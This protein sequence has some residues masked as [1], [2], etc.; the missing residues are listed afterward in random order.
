MGRWKSDGKGGAYWDENDSGP[1]QVQPSPEQRAAQQPQ[2]QSPPPAQ[3]V[4]IWNPGAYRDAK[5]W[6][7][8]D[9]QQGNEWY[10]G[11]AQGLP[12]SPQP[13]NREQFRDEWMSTGT[14]VGRQ[15]ALL[16][17]YGITLDPA[18]RGT[19]QTTD[20]KT[21]TLDLRIGA[22]AG[23]NLAAWTGIGGSGGAAGNEAGSMA[24][25][26]GKSDVASRGNSLNDQLVQQLLGR[27]GQSLAVDRN[28][29][30]IRAQ[31]DAYSANQQRAQ[32]DYLADLAEKS[33]PY[34]NLQGE[35]RLS[36]ERL[37]Q[38]TGAFE[39]QLMGR[40]LD[41]RR[42]EITDALTQ[43]RGML[44][45]DQQL[46]LQR[47]LALIDDATKRLGLNYQNSQFGAQLAQNESQFGRNLGF[48]YESL[49]NA[50]LR[51]LLGSL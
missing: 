33:G 44:T 8:E 5:G 21:E 46:A 31:A 12:S 28:D 47:E 25:I 14:D 4:G 18:G 42:T 36:A 30:V 2:T 51:Q 43:L 9:G 48:Q 40:E 38:Q 1:D 41:T 34:A 22:K 11:G 45:T 35:A 16:S 50:L 7:I 23:Q 15:N 20:G 29:P 17:K 24:G 49:D 37:G 32:R 6:D 10:T 27:A 39:A 3:G 13:V 19:F 26:G